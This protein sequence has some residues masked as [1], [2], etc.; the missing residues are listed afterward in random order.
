MGVHQQICGIRQFEVHSRQA[1]VTRE[2]VARFIFYELSC[3]DGYKTP[4]FF[5]TDGSATYANLLLIQP[6]YGKWKPAFVFRYRLNWFD[7]LDQKAT[8]VSLWRPNY[9]TSSMVETVFCCSYFSTRGT[10]FR[11][12][13]ALN[14]EVPFSV[15]LRGGHLAHLPVVIENNRLLGALSFSARL[16]V[17]SVLLS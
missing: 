17:L 10:S 5:L 8:S 14:S 2:C 16:S 4:L 13:C 1:S 15:Q 12:R 11:R 3:L 7:I 9:K 6:W